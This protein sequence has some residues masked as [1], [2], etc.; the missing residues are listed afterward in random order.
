MDGQLIGWEDS[1]IHVLAHVAHYGSAVFE[2]IRFYETSKTPAVFRLKEHIERLYYSAKAIKLKI[3]FSPQEVIEAVCETIRSNDIKSGY[4]RPLAF[5]G[6]GKMGLNPLGAKQHLCIAVWPWGA[7]L[8]KD[9]VKVK[10]SKYKRLHPES[11]VSDAK[12]SGYYVNS[13]L[14]SQDAHESGYDEALLLDYK[15][16]I[17]EGPGE[18]IFLV[19]NGELFTVAKGSILPG[20]TRATVMQIAKDQNLKCSEKVLTVEDVKTADELFFTGTAAEIQPISQIDDTVI[21][22]GQIGPITQKI[23][24]IYLDAVHGKLPE[25]EHW[26]TFV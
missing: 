26:L 24:D 11:V 15:G 4:I 12:V 17:A 5:Y 21:N 7:Y 23:K 6:Y 1:K 22:G 14:A 10:I 3:N 18:N 19:S 8:G 13:I 2:G 9:A 25:Y 16:N 20:I